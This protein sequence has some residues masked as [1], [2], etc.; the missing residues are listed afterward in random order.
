MMD[1]V[2]KQRLEFEKKILAKYL[3]YFRAHLYGNDPHFVGSYKTTSGG[4]YYRLKLVIPKWYPNEMPWL[5]VVS[6]WRLRKHNYRGS[7]NEEGITHCFHTMKNGP[8][9]CVQI[10]HFKS[11]NWDA[12]QTCAAVFTKGIM[13]CEA[14]DCY[15]ATGR[16]MADIL[17]EFRRR[18][19]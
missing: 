6:P 11:D 17:D 3:P 4:N 13:W 14:Y 16:S 18:I 5:F 9:G 12:S 2:L 15:L 1:R 10:C 8:G 7:I 19:A